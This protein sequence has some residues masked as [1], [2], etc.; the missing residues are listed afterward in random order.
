MVMYWYR[1]TCVGIH[2]FKVPRDK[3]LQMNHKQGANQGQMV[4]EKIEHT[5]MILL[6]TND[7]AR[8]IIYIHE[9]CE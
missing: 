8:V 6:T 1:K 9:D 3:C 7:S 5:S 4:Q 2:I